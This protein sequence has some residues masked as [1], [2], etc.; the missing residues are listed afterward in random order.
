MELLEKCDTLGA[1]TVVMP[2]LGSGNRGI[3]VA[4]CAQFLWAAICLLNSYRKPT[5]LNC[6]KI[7]AYDV[8]VFNGLVEFFNK[9]PKFLGFPTH[10][11]NVSKGT[12][13]MK[14]LASDSKEYNAVV[15]AF[16]KSNPPVKKIVLVMC[17]I[18]YS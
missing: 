10:W 8:I 7:P 4:R 11:G 3:P 12:T 13:E 1:I 5:H 15:A 9:P 18:N 6:I 16:K 17:H 2:V 14:R